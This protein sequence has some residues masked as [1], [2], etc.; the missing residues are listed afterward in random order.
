MSQVVISGCATGIGAAARRGLEAA[1]HQ[2]IG[3]DIKDAEILAD[4]LDAIPLRDRDGPAGRAV[5]VVLALRG[6]LWQIEEAWIDR[7]VR[8]GRAGAVG[9]HALPDLPVTAGREHR[10][11][12]KRTDGAPHAKVSES[13]SWTGNAAAAK[14]AGRSASSAG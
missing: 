3:I 6:R 5:V 2:V 12:E 9:R 4:I 11:E 8:G 1:G 14:A 13:A 10:Q 7:A